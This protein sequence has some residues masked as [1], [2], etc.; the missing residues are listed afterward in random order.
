M[1]IPFD[2]A[3]LVAQD[4]LA[5]GIVFGSPIY[6]ICPKCSSVHNGSCRMCA[7]QGTMR[8]CDVGV[9]VRIDGSRHEGPLQVTQQRFGYY[10]DHSIYALWNIQYFPTREAAEEALAEYEQIRNLEPRAAR[11][12]AYNEWYDRR[13]SKYTGWG[14]LSEVQWAPPIPEDD[15][16]QQLALDID[17]AEEQED[18]EIGSKNM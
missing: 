2:E 5:Q 15:D 4:M 8:V 3:I 18:T 7:W 16:G 1:E 11:L 10:M 6:K 17:K 9:A 12:A 13:R 14:P